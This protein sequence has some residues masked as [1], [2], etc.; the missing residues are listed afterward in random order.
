MSLTALITWDNTKENEI[1][2]RV[3]PIG[4]NFVNVS[5]TFSQIFL[6]LQ[7]EMFTLW[8]LMKQHEARWKL[9]RRKFTGN[10]RTNTS[11]QDSSNTFP[12]AKMH[13]TNETTMKRRWKRAL[14][15]V[16]ILI[17]L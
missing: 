12:F 11:P 4:R 1:F 13:S 8:L 14:F 16:D 5:A 17:E 7:R 6:F 2:D 3:L 15:Q 9:A 10:E